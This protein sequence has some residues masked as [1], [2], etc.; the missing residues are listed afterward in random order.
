[1]QIAPK[2]VDEAARLETL[3]SLSILDTP[4]EERFDRLTRLARRL[5]DVPIAL[6]SLVDENRQWFKSHP[7][8]DATQTS[9]DI[10]FCA[11]A[12]LADETMVIQDARNDDRFHDNPLVTGQPGIRFY[13]GRRLPRRTAHPSARCA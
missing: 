11:H 12:L 1:M 4:P 7:G 2:P 3:H 5:F 13:A 10:S 9:R 6:V 8:L